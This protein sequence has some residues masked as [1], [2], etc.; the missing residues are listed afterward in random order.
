MIDLASR[1]EVLVL[2][3]DLYLGL[4][5]QAVVVVSTMVLLLRLLP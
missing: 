2:K 4:A 5:L 1:R 3:K